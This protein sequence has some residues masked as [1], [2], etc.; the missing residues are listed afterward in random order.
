MAFQ[1]V[2]VAKAPPDRPGKPEPAS[3]EGHKGKSLPPGLQKQVN[4]GRPL[5]PGWQD[6]LQ[7]GQR[8]DDEIFNHGVIIASEPR[9]GHISIRVDDRVIRLIAATHEIIDVLRP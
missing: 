6:K 5:P 4:R 9:L 7:V 3:S 1:G 2:S 8:L